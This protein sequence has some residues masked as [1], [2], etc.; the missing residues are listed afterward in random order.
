MPKTQPKPAES[1][2]VKPSTENLEPQLT[3]LS[4][5]DRYKEAYF[6]I[7]NKLD[8]KTKKAVELKYRPEIDNFVREVC[9]LSESFEEKPI[10]K[11]IKKD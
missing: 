3:H 2:N 11:E 7:F 8:E 5:A 4:A 10:D 9:R 1:P 6:I